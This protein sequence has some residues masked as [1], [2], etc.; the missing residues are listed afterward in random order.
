MIDYDEQPRHFKR[1]T[2]PRHKKYGIEQYSR[3]FHRWCGRTWYITEKARD[4]AFDNLMAK[5]DAVKKLKSINF[6]FAP[7]R[8]V[9]R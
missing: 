1:A 3:W 9:N 2:K 6:E 7:I 8:K 5:T 4:Q